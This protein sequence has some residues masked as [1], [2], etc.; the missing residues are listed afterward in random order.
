MRAYRGKQNIPKHR[1]VALPGPV[2]VISPNA[3]P[4]DDDL[5]LFFEGD[6]ERGEAKVQ[7]EKKAKAI[8]A[9]CPIETRQACL[10]TALKAEGNARTGRYGIFAGL[11]GVERARLAK[12]RQEEAA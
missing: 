11:N 3:R 12:R 9:T 6:G 8:C 2:P 7:R 4:C 1:T 5:D 10:D